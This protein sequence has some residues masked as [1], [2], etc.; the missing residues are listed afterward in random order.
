MEW[1]GKPEDVDEL[2]ITMEKW[3]GE[4]QNTIVNEKDGEVELR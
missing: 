3:D 1:N 4:T 2:W